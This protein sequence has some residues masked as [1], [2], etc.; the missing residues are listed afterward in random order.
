MK[1]F[2]RYIFGSRTKKNRKKEIKAISGNSGYGISDIYDAEGLSG[3]GGAFKINGVLHKYLDGAIDLG[4]DNPG[5][6]L[7]FSADFNATQH[8]AQTLSDKLKH[9][10]QYK[11]NQ[12][13]PNKNINPVY[14]IGNSFRGSF[15]SKS[16]KVFNKES[17]TIAIAGITSDVLQFIAIEI[18]KELKLETILVR[19]FNNDGWPSVFFVKQL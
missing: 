15:N 19:D 11:W 1:S 12:L 5:G 14:T 8:P 4:Q 18:C 3:M 10:F 6:I 13:L 16:G 7:I 9:F 2:V 17:Y